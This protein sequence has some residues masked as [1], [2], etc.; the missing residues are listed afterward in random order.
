MESGLFTLSFSGFIL[1]VLTFFVAGIIDAAAGG[2]GLLTLPVFM[3]TG[4]PV[5]M[6]AGTNMAS[7]VA[8]A[9]ASV[10][11][12]SK[13]KKIYWQTA[14]VAGVLSLAGSYFGSKLNIMIP[15]K[16][17]QYIM[18]V[19]LPVAAIVIFAKK[20]IGDENNVEMLSMTAKMV[21]AVVFGFLMG[22]YEGFYGA[23]AG[24]FMIFGFVL[25][26]KLDLVTASGNSRVMAVFSSIGTTVTF[27]LEGL[28]YWPVVLWVTAGYIGGSCLGSSLALKKGARFIKPVFAVVLLLLFLRLVTQCLRQGLKHL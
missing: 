2:G 26:N 21:F 19:I 28:V 13:N 12:Y 18:I 24:T 15:E 17:L 6:I 14:L 16:Y 10:I 27:A 22:V 4:F 3:L 20:N 9:T 8:G 5:H 25:L 23:G 7:T 11:R 1:L